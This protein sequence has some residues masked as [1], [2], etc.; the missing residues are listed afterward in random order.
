MKPSYS[1]DD[2]RLFW[3]VAEAG[4]FRQA[5]TVLGI[6]PSTLSRRINAL[7]QALGLRLLHRDAHRI[8]LTGTGRQYLE[9]CGPLFSELNDISGELHAE[10]HQPAG[11]LRIAVPVNTMYRWLATAL[12]QFQLR[13]PKIDLDIRMSNWVIDVGEHAI[14][15]AIRVGEPRLQGWIARPLTIVQSLL[16]ASS[17]ATQWHHIQHPSELINY[18]LI[19]SS[20]INV[21]RF[22]HQQHQQQIDYS[23]QGNI[24][25]SVD[26]MNMAMQAIEAG[27]GIGYLPR[28][29]VQEYM[30]QGRLVG[31]AT[32]WQGP[33]RDTY[34][35]YR[36]RDNQPLRLRLLIEHLLE[37]APKEY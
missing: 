30:Q 20:P 24:R 19:V 23:P 31:L 21:W 4:S 3:V 16:C 2:M 25:L 28:R 1:L 35:L 17:Q 26:D 9:R 29:V 11:V 15:L 6:P 33:K 37:V 22:I 10:K 12:N 8:N 18:P 13:Y 7:E 32:D 36:D 5:A 14:D 27:V 34:L